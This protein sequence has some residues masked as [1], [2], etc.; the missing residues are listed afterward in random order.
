M[1]FVN[2]TV[3]V[4]PPPNLCNTGTL[5]GTKPMFDDQ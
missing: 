5:P 1:V 3:T 4:N 2:A